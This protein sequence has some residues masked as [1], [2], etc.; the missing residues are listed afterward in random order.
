MMP[1]TDYEESSSDDSFEHNFL[2][3]SKYK[4]HKE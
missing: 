4:K 3:H 2:K 1:E